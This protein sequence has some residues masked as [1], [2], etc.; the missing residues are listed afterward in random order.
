MKR[1]QSL[2]LGL[3]ISVAT[4]AFAMRGTDFNQL[5]GELAHGRYIYF[6]PAIILCGF[7]LF[8]RGVRWRALLNGKISLPHSFNIL[9]ASYLFNTILPMRLGE[10]VR[11]YM[12]TRITPPISMFTSL[13]TVLV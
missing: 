4:L 1:W 9:N 12:A 7:G 6:I 8:L 10:V 13:S 5:G 11:A 3:V 2:L